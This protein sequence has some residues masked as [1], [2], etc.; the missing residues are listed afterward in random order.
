MQ[1]TALH[2]AIIKGH[3]ELAMYIIDQGPDLE[4]EDIDNK[5]PVSDSYFFVNVILFLTIALACS[6]A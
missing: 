4:A 5:T 3:K 1:M 6:L 2:I